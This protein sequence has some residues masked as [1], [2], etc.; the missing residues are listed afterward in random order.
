[1]GTGIRNC[2]EKKT[3]IEAKPVAGNYFSC[4]AQMP[5]DSQ[6]YYKISSSGSDTLSVKIKKAANKGGEKVPEDAMWCDYGYSEEEENPQKNL[7][8]CP[9]MK[10]KNS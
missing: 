6:Y 7:S 5:D 4:I 1:M 10:P 3:L 8:G 9:W 2:S